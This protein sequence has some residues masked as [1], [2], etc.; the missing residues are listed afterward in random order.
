MKLYIGGLTYTLTEDELSKVFA[1]F[2]E[3]VS[4]SII[5]D[6]ETNQSKGFGFVEMKEN[7]DA[8]KAIQAMNGKEL[9]GRT[10]TVNQARPQAEKG[11]GSTSFR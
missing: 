4:V 7:E 1:E 2:G 3:V 8:Q 5:K 10:V 11:S 9:N 6:R